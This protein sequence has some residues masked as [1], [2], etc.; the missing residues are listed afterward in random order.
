MQ[1]NYHLSD[2][3]FL[4][5]NRH[6]LTTSE[7]GKKKLMQQFLPG[8]I[9]GIVLLIGLYFIGAS[10]TIFLMEV[11]VVVVCVIL[12]YVKRVDTCMNGFKKNLEQSKK[13]GKLAYNSKGVISFSEDYI[14]DR[15]EDTA[16]V[17]KM[18]CAKISKIYQAASA[19]Y[20]YTNDTTAIL[21]PYSMF[22]KDSDKEAVKDYLKQHTSATWIQA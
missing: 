3:D 7:E 1:F 10:T 2:E 11:A 14:E 22:E 4:E 5:F 20:V 17:T 8:P 15:Q 12:M 16:S 18:E 9:F 13:R 21:L 19:F 6:Y